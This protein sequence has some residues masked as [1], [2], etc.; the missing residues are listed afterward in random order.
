MMINIYVLT[1]RL[2][3]GVTRG[4]IGEPHLTRGAAVES[5]RGWLAD[6]NDGST[7]DDATPWDSM[8]EDALIAEAGDR[9]HEA[10]IEAYCV[11]LDAEAIE[12][13]GSEGGSPI[14]IAASLVALSEALHARAVAVLNAYEATL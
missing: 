2:T 7:S 4:A 14:L 3:R 1:T 11:E 6:L 13:T 9:G 12:I 8:D 5:L 10:G